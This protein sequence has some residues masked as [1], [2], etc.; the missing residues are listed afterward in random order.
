MKA[1]KKI[2]LGICIT[3]ILLTGILMAQGA[4]SSEASTSSTAASGSATTDATSA[5]STSTADSTTDWTAIIDSDPNTS[6]LV[7]VIESDGD[8]DEVA[9]AMYLTGTDTLISTIPEGVTIFAPVDG[10]FD[11]DVAVEDVITSYIIPGIVD[12]ADMASG[13]STTSTAISGDPL[14]IAVVNEVVT[15]NGVPVL[16]AEAIYTDNAVIYKLSDSFVSND[17]ASTK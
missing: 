9:E 3:G 8:L 11:Q 14:T 6:Q 5:T 7:L 4:S 17:L 15:V 10:S 1:T 13:D 2:G 12:T 16:D